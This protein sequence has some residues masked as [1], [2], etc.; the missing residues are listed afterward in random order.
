MKNESVKYNRKLD[1][2]DKEGDAE[3]VRKIYENLN[4]NQID[5]MIDDVFVAINSL[6]I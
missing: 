1:K 3:K 2:N 6:S 5:K 4:R